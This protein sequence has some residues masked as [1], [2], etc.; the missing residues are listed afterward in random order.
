MQCNFLGYKDIKS[1]Y[2]YQD[3]CIAGPSEY[4]TTTE[5]QNNYCKDNFRECPRYLTKLQLEQFHQK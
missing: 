5:D 3:N 2:S 1:N 4:L